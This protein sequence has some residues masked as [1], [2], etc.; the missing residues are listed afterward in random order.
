MNAFVYNCLNSI[1]ESNMSKFVIYYII[2]FSVFPNRQLRLRLEDI[3]FRQAKF[4]SK[5][6]KTTI[7]NFPFSVTVLY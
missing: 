5:S 1:F 4:L 6:I 3:R 7:G 2:N